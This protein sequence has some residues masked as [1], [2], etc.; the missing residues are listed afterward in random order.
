MPQETVPLTVQGHFSKRTARTCFDYSKSKG[1][2]S[3]SSH[4]CCLPIFQTTFDR[5][6]FLHQLPRCQNERVCKIKLPAANTLSLSRGRW[7][8][9]WASFASQSLYEVGSLGRAIDVVWSDIVDARVDVRA[10]DLALKVLTSMVSCRLPKAM[11]K[12]VPC[13]FK[14]QLQRY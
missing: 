4:P 7:D 13:N 11:H 8:L 9:A 14:A 3:C 5:Q 6:A 2:V 10:D 1:I 12:P